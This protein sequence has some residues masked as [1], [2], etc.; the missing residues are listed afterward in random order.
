VLVHE[1]VDAFVREEEQDVVERAAG[2]ID[3]APAGELAHPG[4]HVP[5]ERLE[6]GGAAALQVAHVVRHRELHVHVEHLAAGQQERDVGDGALRRGPLL[7]VGDALDQ[8]GE[9][10]HVVG[11][12]LAPLAAGLGRGEHLAQRAGGG[13]EQRRL[14]VGAHEL[15]AQLAVGAGH[16]LLQPTQ[17]GP[18][19]GQV[20]H[21]RRHPPAPREPAGHQR[22]HR[23]EDHHDRHAPILTR[24]CDGEGSAR[25]AEDEEAHLGAEAY[26]LALV[27]RA[28]AVVALGEV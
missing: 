1:G 9:A 13:G 16:R 18:H 4:P 22:H 11:H 15:L 12:A 20:A 19:P 24:G 3:V 8:A 25:G 28:G 10:Q 2:R 23:N 27:V 14:L 5:Q 21:H 6:L 17:L 7:L 26:A